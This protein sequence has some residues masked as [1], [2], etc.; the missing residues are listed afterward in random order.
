MK[1]ER[2]PMLT[3]ARPPG[4]ARPLCLFLSFHSVLWKSS[5]NAKD[6][7]PHWTKQVISSSTLTFVPHPVLSSRSGDIVS[8][9]QGGETQ[10]HHQMDDFS[11]FFS[12]VM[13]HANA[14]AAPSESSPPTSSTT[15][16]F[17]PPTPSS[18]PPPNASSLDNSSSSSTTNTTIE[19]TSNNYT[20]VISPTPIGRQLPCTPVAYYA[21]DA[22]TL[23]PHGRVIA[24]TGRYICYAL[25]VS[26]WNLAETEEDWGDYGRGYLILCFLHHHHQWR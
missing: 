6:E 19:I 18:S 15:T 1:R 8:Q 12:S 9:P 20:H 24:V 4:R 10:E 11:K 17:K 16:T 26:N 7:T 3:G 2:L 14:P 23:N 25:K 22:S 21:T 5:L 13:G